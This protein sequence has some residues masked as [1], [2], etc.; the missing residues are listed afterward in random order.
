MVALLSPPISQT[1][2]AG[3]VEARR[4]NDIA[5]LAATLSKAVLRGDRFAV[6]TAGN[7]DT[8]GHVLELLA[9]MLAEH[10]VH[11]ELRGP[12]EIYRVSDG[13]NG[14]GPGSELASWA[15]TIDGDPYAR[16]ALFVIEGAETLKPETIE[17]LWLASTVLLAGPLAHAVNITSPALVS[18]SDLRVMGPPAGSTDLT[19]LRPGCQGR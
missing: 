7:A 3:F 6:L 15:S 19:K 17:F 18:Q 9:E 13:L 12:E 1:S 14:G 11:V 10:D 2:F 5:G 4:A 16:R 8:R